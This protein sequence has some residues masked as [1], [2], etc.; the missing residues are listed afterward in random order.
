[1]KTNQT[2]LRVLTIATLACQ[3][4]NLDVPNLE[5]VDLPGLQNRLTVLHQRLNRNHN[6]LDLFFWQKALQR[7]VAQK[8]PQRQEFQWARSYWFPVDN[9]GWRQ[10]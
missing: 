9:H 8:S 5:E 2:A 6:G 3:P 10:V 4:L 7:L 1:M